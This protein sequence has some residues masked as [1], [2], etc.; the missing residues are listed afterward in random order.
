[1]RDVP[2]LVGDRGRFNEKVVGRIGEALARPLEVDDRVN[3]YVC[4]VYAFWPEF[5]RDGFGEDPLSRLGRRET[6]EVGSAPQCRGVAAGDDCALP[7]LDPSRCH[8]PPPT[9]PTHTL[10]PHFPTPP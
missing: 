10:P 4:D 5:P 9:P 8:P 2:D 7:P 6:S 3:Q 1:M